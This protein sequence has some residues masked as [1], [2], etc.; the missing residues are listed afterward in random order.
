VNHVSGEEWKTL[1]DSI[2]D[3]NV[4][5]V[6]GSDALL[7]E[8]EAESGIHWTMPFYRLVATDLLK[9]YESLVELCSLFMEKSHR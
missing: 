5:P 6:I 9:A 1:I 2:W 4:I 8:F 3:G 7:V